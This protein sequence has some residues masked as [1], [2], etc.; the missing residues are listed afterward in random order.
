MRSPWGPC[1]RDTSLIT[2]RSL[3][4]HLRHCDDPLAPSLSRLVSDRTPDMGHRFGEVVWHHRW[5]GGQ[6]SGEWIRGRAGHQH[7]TSTAERAKLRSLLGRIHGRFR[8][9]TAARIPGKFHGGLTGSWSARLRGISGFR[10]KLWSTNGRP[11][12]RLWGSMNKFR[13]TM[14]SICISVLLAW[15][16]LLFGD[17]TLPRPGS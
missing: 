3:V 17:A 2:R 11:N 16:A 5:R 1:N 12:G 7:C 13:S 15:P 6:G 8:I 10:V 14:G 4:Q 9:G